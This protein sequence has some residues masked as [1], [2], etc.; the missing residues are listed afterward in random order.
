MQTERFEFTYDNT[1]FVIWAWKGDYINLGAGAELGIYYNGGTELQFTGQ[2]KIYHWYTGKDY[3][4]PM[5]LRLEDSEGTQLFDWAP[6]EKNWWITGF[7]PQHQ[8]VYAE[9]LTATY[10]I[11]FSG[12]KGMFD[13]FYEKWGQRQN[14]PWTFDK[15]NYKA[16]LTF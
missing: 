10:T 4:M 3:K 1:Y 16:K 7:D 5:T 14:T 13:A 11:D 12:N 2:E 9:N 8:G 15:Q 6:E